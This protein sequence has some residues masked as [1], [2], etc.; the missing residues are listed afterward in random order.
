MVSL[1]TDD[2]WLET[3]GSKV[4]FARQLEDAPES[5]FLMHQQGLF[6]GKAV[7]TLDSVPGYYGGTASYKWVQNAKALNQIRRTRNMLTPEAPERDA[8]ELLPTLMPN[9]ARTA[10]YKAAKAVKDAMP[11]V[12]T[13]ARGT[14]YKTAGRYDEDKS[15]FQGAFAVPRPRRD[16]KYEGRPQSNFIKDEAGNMVYRPDIV[17]ERAANNPLAQA[18]RA[19]I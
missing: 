1:S 2:S 11:G 19:V 3:P 18:V 6:S 7:G 17:A 4:L 5:D 10:A 15:A 14:L 16:R 8:P 12:K 9:E 13:P